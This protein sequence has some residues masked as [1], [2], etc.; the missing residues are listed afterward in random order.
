MPKTRLCST[1]PEAERLS[2]LQG[3]PPEQLAHADL[4]LDLA[5]QIVPADRHAAGAQDHVVGE[6]PLQRVAMGLARVGRGADHGHLGARGRERRPQQRAVRVVD[7]AGLEPL[8]RGAQFTAGGQHGDLR[9]RTAAQRAQ[10]QRRRG[11]DLAGAEPDAGRQHL[12]AAA[13]VAAGVAHRVAVWHRAG[14]RHGLTPRQDHRSLHPLDRGHAVR[15]VR[16]RRSGGDGHGLSGADETAERRA[17]RRLADQLQL[18]GGVAVAQRVAVHRRVG[19]RRQIER[20]QHRFGEVAVERGVER[21]LLHRQRTHLLE[22]AAERIVDRHQRLVTHRT[23][24]GV[25]PAVH[26]CCGYRR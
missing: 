12:L 20:R 6:R 11:T 17:G 24:P 2:R 3:D 1:H 7:L 8:S 22:H 26:A 15:A 5:H 21:D 4:A 13:H 23:A 18:T 25:S 19:E 10:P 14:N 16:Q 9:Q